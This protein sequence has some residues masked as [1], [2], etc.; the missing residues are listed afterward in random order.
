MKITHRTTD[1]FKS[2]DHAKLFLDVLPKLYWMITLL[3]CIA[4]LSFAV[5]LVA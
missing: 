5:F 3:T 2:V 1:G 4:F